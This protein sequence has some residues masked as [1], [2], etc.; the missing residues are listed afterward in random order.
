MQQAREAARRAQCTNN[1][2]QIG[3]ALINYDSTHKTLPMA[4]TISDA[5]GPHHFSWISQI[6]P[7]ME[8]TALY[9]RLDWTLPAGHSDNA[10]YLTTKVEFL[11]CPSDP[12]GDPGE[13]LGNVMSSN[14]SGAEGL[15]SDN[16]ANLF[17]GSTGNSL[18]TALSGTNIDTGGRM[19]LNGIFR[20]GRATRFA[21]IKDGASNT[22]MAAETT[23]AGYD[24]GESRFLDDSYS[25]TAFIGA[26]ESTSGSEAL[27][28]DD[29]VASGSYDGYVPASPAL[30]S[31]SSAKLI[32][33]TYQ[34]QYAINANGNGASTPHNVLISVLGDGSVQTVPLTVDGVVWVQLNCMADASVFEKP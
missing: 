29:Y 9:D 14:Y 34:A 21:K 13:E 33:P 10:G 26:Y 32:T 28:W 20:P 6:L 23:V 24:A 25:R 30:P 3:L 5:S 16:G 2:K 17:G 22:I 8:Q 1:L 12:N 15:Y 11:V 19:D 7:Q 4:S 27:G 31:G 18:P